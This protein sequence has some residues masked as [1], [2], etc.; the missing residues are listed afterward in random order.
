MYI[1]QI[2]MKPKV[3][4]NCL[5]LNILYSFCAHDVNCLEFLTKIE[6]LALKYILRAAAVLQMF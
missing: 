5:M 3:G 6:Y 2:Y 4:F 1:T